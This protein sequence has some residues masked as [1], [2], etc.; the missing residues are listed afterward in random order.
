MPGI[1]AGSVPPERL[2][3]PWYFQQRITQVGGKNRYGQPNFK[4]AWAQTETVRQGGEW[5][6]EGETFTGYQ[7]VL[8][9]DGHPH[10]MLMQW[11]D[12]GMS[13][14]LPHLRPVCDVAWYD[15]NRCHRTGLSL[16]GGYPY[17][18][19]YQIVLPLVAKVKIENKL[20]IEAFPLSTEIIN[21]MVPIIVASMEVSLKAKMMFLKDQEELEEDARAK[22]FEDIYQNVKRKPTLASTAWLEEKQRAIEKHYNAAAVALLARNRR[23]QTNRPLSEIVG[24]K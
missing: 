21:M 23:L 24:Q 10:W 9:G 8:K 18:G 4:L 17:Q 19:S 20:Y 1:F 2:K 14:E 16:L 15:E 6:A 13:A 5:E 11:V 7:D 12:A 3:C 22:V